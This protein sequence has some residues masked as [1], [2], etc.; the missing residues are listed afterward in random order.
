MRKITAVLFVALLMT[1]SA[2]AKASVQAAERAALAW[3]ALIDQAEYQQAWE[4]AS[5][6]LKTPL[7]ATML[8]RTVSLARRDRGAVQSRQR[9][10]VSQYRSMPNAPRND[11]KEFT[12][13]TQFENGRSVHEVV[14]PHLESGV[15]RVSGY[16]IK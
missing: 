1:F 13:R 5:P 12:F 16:Y 14:T 15:W 2:H 11:Y 7:S 3:L 9:V 10:R 6:L 4:E 8:Q